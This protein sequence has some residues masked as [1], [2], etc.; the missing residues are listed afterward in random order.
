MI[1]SHKYKFIF[2]KTKKTA[3]TSI[4]IFLSK[5]CGEEDIITPIS[6]EDEEI[7]K[8]LGYRLAQNYQDSEGNQ[9]FYSHIPASKVKEIIGSEIWDSYYKICFERN[10]WEKVISFYFWE[11]KTE[12]RPS[13]SEFIRANNLKRLFIGENALYLI[14]NEIAVD[15]VCY[16]ENL[17]SELEDFFKKINIIDSDFQLPTAKSKFR[18]DKRDY[19]K[20]LSQKDIDYIAKLFKREIETFY[21]RHLAKY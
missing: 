14:D 8:K 2:I 10:P 21:I 19:R 11:Y 6:P 3:G 20:I 13:I 16:Y 18:K 7:R 17:N 1:I 15:R 5:Y 4:E 9:I 12:P